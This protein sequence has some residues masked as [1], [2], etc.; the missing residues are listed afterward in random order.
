MLG[1]ERT[2]TV[3]GSNHQRTTGTAGDSVVTLRLQTNPTHCLLTPDIQKNSQGGHS[4][5]PLLQRGALKPRG[6]RRLITQGVIQ[7]TN[8]RART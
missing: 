6:A 5:H 3:V 8:D 4:F 1:R 7:L 2:A